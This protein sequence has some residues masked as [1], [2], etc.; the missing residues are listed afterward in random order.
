MKSNITGYQYGIYN[1]ADTPINLQSGTI[2]ATNTG[3]YNNSNGQIDIDIIDGVVPKISGT[4][5]GIYNFKGTLNLNNGEI[6]SDGTGIYSYN[7][8][9]N[10]ADINI[11]GGTINGNIG[12]E[13]TNNNLNING[14]TI[15]GKNIG[16]LSSGNNETFNM[17]EGIITSSLSK[18]T[19]LSLDNYTANT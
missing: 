11:N 4:T 9:I 16:V 1:N 6:S 14:G 19:G 7:N 12:I 15:N 3:I 5:Y 2:S 18:G 17:T 10:S 13:N 8:T